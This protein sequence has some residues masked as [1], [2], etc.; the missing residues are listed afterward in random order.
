MEAW[1]EKLAE[2]CGTYK[3]KYQ[4]L[5]DHIKILVNMNDPEFSQKQLREI[6]TKQEVENA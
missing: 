6:V 1:I 5:L 4:I 3:V 2:E